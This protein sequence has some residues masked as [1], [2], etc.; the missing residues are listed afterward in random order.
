MI[1]LFNF[2]CIFAVVS[3]ASILISAG[4]FDVAKY[5]SQYTFKDANITKVNVNISEVLQERSKYTNAVTLWITK[6]WQEDWYDIKTTQRKIINK[7]Y[8]PVFIFYW[9]GDD[10]S[11]EYILKNEKAYFRSLEKFVKYLKK[12]DG[13]KIVVLNP[14]YNMFGT[15]AWDGMNDIFLKSYKI[16]RQDSQALVGPCVGDFGDYNNTNEP[17]EWILFDKSLNRAAKKADFLAFQEMRGLTKNSKEDILKTPERALSFAKYLNKKYKKP[18]ML[19]YLAVSSYGENGE[20]IQKEV[21]KDFVRLLPKMKKEAS[22]MLFG[23]FHYFDY[24]GHVGYFNEA[25]EYFGVLRKDGTRK[26]SFTY[27]NFLR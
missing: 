27:F 21:Y 12:L 9:F 10:V 25:E 11:I 17:D 13:Q 5:K 3:S 23:T 1:K 19:A 6:D 4:G 20:E 7:G 15:Q 22:M 24:P 26:P 18:T 8:T 2:L 14:E 16:V